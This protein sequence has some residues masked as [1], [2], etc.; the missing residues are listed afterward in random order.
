MFAD[1]SL[2]EGCWQ[3]NKQHGFGRMI[4]TD[5]SV[6]QGYWRNDTHHGRGA[7]LW[8]E[9]K[10]IYKYKGNFKFGNRGGKGTLVFPEGEML[11]GIWVNG[12]I[13]GRFTFCNKSRTQT[14]YFNFR[15]KFM[16]EN[17]FNR[18]KAYLHPMEMWAYK[19]FEIQTQFN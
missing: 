10:Q 6:Y 2:Y 19:T 17:Q 11:A 16:S 7:Y 1:G 9:E 4:Y 8:F 14:G 15:P 12:K 3:M 5:G 13:S 18:I